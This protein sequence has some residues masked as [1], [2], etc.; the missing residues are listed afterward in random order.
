MQYI[1]ARFLLLINLFIKNL[2]AI[3]YACDVNLKSRLIRI[4]ILDQSRHVKRE[5][6]QIKFKVYFNQY[7]WN[8]VF[9]K[10]ING[11]SYSDKI[12]LTMNCFGGIC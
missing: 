11:W 1:K 7:L 10:L 12:N 8:R 5:I 6:T 4:Y 3:L 2:L 9:R